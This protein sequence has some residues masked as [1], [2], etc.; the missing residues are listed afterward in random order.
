VIFETARVPV[1]LFP[2][3]LEMLLQARSVEPGTLCQSH[4]ILACLAVFAYQAINLGRLPLNQGPGDLVGAFQAHRRKRLPTSKDKTG[5]TLASMIGTCGHYGLRPVPGLCS[6][7]RRAQ[8]ARLVRR[9]RPHWTDSIARTAP[10][11]LNA[12]RTGCPLC[13]ITTSANRLMGWNFFIGC[14]VT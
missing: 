12:L 14:V 3:F 10:K 2:R 1:I 7:D 4:M 13:V 11:L 5:N 8:L 9:R 6:R